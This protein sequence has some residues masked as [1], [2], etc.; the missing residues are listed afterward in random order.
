[1]SLAIAKNTCSTASSLA[2]YIPCKRPAYL[3]LLV[4]SEHIYLAAVQPVLE[5]LMRRFL[6]MFACQVKVQKNIVNLVQQG[7]VCFVACTG[8]LSK[9]RGN[10]VPPFLKF[11]YP[12]S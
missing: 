9:V 1:M 7:F 11:A 3:A 8:F 2:V 5:F 10:A 6:V 4:H 12:V